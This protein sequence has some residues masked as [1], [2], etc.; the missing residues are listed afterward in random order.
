MLRPRKRRSGPTP[1]LR[2][3]EMT[4]TTRTTTTAQRKT[5]FIHIQI[6]N[7]R[8]K[9]DLMFS[10]YDKTYCTCARPHSRF[11]STLAQ[12]RLQ[13]I[14]YGKLAAHRGVT[15]SNP[16]TIYHTELHSSYIKSGGDSLQFY[17]PCIT[18]TLIF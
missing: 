9:M 13:S 15:Q 16:W 17:V 14:L 11:S 2:T 8:D 12:C 4:T 3:S 10:L 6:T 7:E 18:P 1:V 5:N